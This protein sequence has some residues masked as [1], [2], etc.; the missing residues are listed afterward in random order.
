M[1]LLD[2]MPSKYVAT[3]FF[4]N[5]RILSVFRFFSFIFALLLEHSFNCIYVVSLTHCIC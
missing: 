5:S 1:I 2:Y 3:L 4:L